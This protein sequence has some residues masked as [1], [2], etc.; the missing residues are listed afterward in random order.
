MLMVGRSGDLRGITQPHWVALY[1]LLGN[2]RM[3]PYAQKRREAGRPVWA[4]MALDG[5]F[6]LRRLTRTGRPSEPTQQTASRCASYAAHA[7]APSL[8]HQRWG[9]PGGHGGGQGMDG[10]CSIGHEMDLSSMIGSESYR[11]D[12]RH[13]VD[14]RKTK[15][16]QSRTRSVCVRWFDKTAINGQRE[17]FPLLRTR[18]RARGDLPSV[19][20]TSSARPGE[21]VEGLGGVHFFHTT[22]TTTW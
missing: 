17:G 5:R 3:T 18:A 7:R 13:Q 20:G 16:I 2:T 19:R 4:D 12:A 6:L 10:I 11:C 8:A 15:K 1:G 14:E 22:T 21:K 9:G